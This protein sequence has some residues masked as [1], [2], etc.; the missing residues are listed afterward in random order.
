M[1]FKKR[2]I[3]IDIELQD[4][5]GKTF[6]GM[7]IDCEVEKVGLPDKN[8]AN[9][10]IYGLT[11]EDMERFTVL[12]FKPLEYRKNTLKIRAGE[13]E[14][15]MGQVFVGDIMSAYADFSSAPDVAFH[16]EAQTGLFATLTPQAPETVQGEATADELLGK[17]A[18]E[19]GFAYSSEGDAGKAQIRDTVLQGSP[20]DKGAAIAEHLGNELIVDDEEMILIDNTGVRVNANPVT[21]SVETG[22]LGYPSFTSE[23]VACR[24]LYNPNIFYASVLNLESLVPKASGEWRITKVVHKLSAFKANGGPWETQIEAVTRIV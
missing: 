22:L 4:G 19:S 6:S 1:A 5:G 11:L 17:I 7:G 8:K 15:E 20:W 10:T 3:E 12:A 14:G 24:S 23:G 18:G 13:E 16:I 9:V 21:L 2:V